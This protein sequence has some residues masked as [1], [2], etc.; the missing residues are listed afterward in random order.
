MTRFS[1]GRWRGGAWLA[2]AAVLLAGCGGS[3]HQASATSPSNLQATTTAS[4][5]QP[6]PASTT[7]KAQPTTSRSTSAPL[8]HLTQRHFRE[9]GDAVC[10][11]VRF[12]S[13]PSLHPPVTASKLK[14]YAL[15]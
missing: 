11:A 6:A 1:Q 4:T 10:R 3:S 5:A 13:A 15:Q 8:K 12:G 14:S 2:A 9:L 7:V